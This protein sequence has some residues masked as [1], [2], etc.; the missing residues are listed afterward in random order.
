[1]QRAR[2]AIA[3]LAAGLILSYPGLGEIIDQLLAAANT[4][5]GLCLGGVVIALIITLGTV[6]VSLVAQWRGMINDQN[7]PVDGSYPLQRV[8][9]RDGSTT[10]IVPDNI[11]DVGVRVLPNGEVVAISQNIPACHSSL[12]SAPRSKANTACRPLFPVTKFIRP[13]VADGSVACWAAMGAE[14][15]QLS[16][17]HA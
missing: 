15:A 10:I 12:R 8:R 17:R 14:V 13:L 5:A 2:I 7:R 6:M 16:P 3:L 1:M 9:N 4:T 11:Y